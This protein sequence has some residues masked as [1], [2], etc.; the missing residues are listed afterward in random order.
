MATRQEHLAW[1][2]Q[3]A[4]AYLDQSPPDLKEGFASMSSD[5]EKHPETQGHIGNVMG[6]MML[7]NGQLNTV[8]AMRDFI[9]GYN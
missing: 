5:L 9:E 3:R 1:C 6:V 2:K 4:L 8:E 7:L